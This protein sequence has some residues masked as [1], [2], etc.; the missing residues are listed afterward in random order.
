V[1]SELD[2]YR[3]ANILVREYGPEQA[4][5]MAAMRAGTLLQLRDLEGLATWKTILRAVLEL[6]RTELG[7]DE[8]VN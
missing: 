6:T 1:T 3:V 5:F 7:P 2:I 4:P 8:R